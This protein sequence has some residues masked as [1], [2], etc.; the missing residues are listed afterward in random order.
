[1]GIKRRRGVNVYS[2]WRWRGASA[3]FLLQEWRGGLASPE[4][5]SPG[6]LQSPSYLADSLQG[7]T[8]LTHPQVRPLA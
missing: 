3:L 6:M 2:A 5:L 4:D 8:L 1:M 7:C